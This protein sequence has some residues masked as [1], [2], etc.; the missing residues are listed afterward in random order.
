[1]QNNE[2]KI[3][4]LVRIEE[5]RPISKNKRWIVREIVERAIQI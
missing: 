1:M 4:D 3:G 5:T 2:C